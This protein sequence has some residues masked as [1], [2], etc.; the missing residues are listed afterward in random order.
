MKFYT[1]EQTRAALPFDRL[2]PALEAAFR[3]GCE[4]PSRHVHVVSEGAAGRNLLGLMP[5]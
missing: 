1:S 5:A 2:I 4:S 3:Q